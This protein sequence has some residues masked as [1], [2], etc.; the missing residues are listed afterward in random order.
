MNRRAFLMLAAGASLGLL[1]ACASGAQPSSPLAAT[2][3]SPGGSASPKPAGSSAAQAK[4]APSSSGRTQ[5]SI[6]ALGAVSDAGFFI[7]LERG[8][9][10]AAGIDIKF[11]PFDN[12]PAM[13]PAVSTGQLDA[14][15]AASGSALF[16]ALSRGLDLKMVAD[17]GS[18]RPGFA[19]GFVCI[20]KDLLS[21]G[22]VKAYGDLKGR[23]VAVPATGGTA[24]ITVDKTLQQGGLTIKDVDLTSLAYPEMA[25]AMANKAIAACLAIEP[26]ATQMAD[27]GLANSLPGV[28]KIDPGSESAV[29]IYGAKLSKDQPDLGRRFMMGYLRAVQD[30]DAA[31][32]NGKDKAAVIQILAK[33]TA[34]KDP[35]LYER[36]TLPGLNPDGR[37]NLPNLETQQDY[38]LAHGYQKQKVDLAQYVSNDFADK[39]TAALKAG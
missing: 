19:N 13:I 23:K 12:G 32:T 17:K 6:G 38:Y 35:A 15:G 26:F 25:A 16:N 22:T 20:R 10:A 24:E 3:S 9:Y 1:A 28:D 5:L 39:A 27:K 8:Y 30:Y 21:S 7:G 34:V 31:F 36:M 29:V 33:H 4:P 14:A 11:V 18:N 37:V 2:A